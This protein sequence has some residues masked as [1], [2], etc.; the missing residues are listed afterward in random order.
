MAWLIKPVGQDT[1]LLSNNIDIQEDDEVFVIPER[2][3][4]IPYPRKVNIHSQIDDQGF[5]KDLVASDLKTNKDRFGSIWTEEIELNEEY[6]RNKE[7]I[8]YRVAYGKN[9]IYSVSQDYFK[10]IG[11]GRYIYALANREH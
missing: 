10:F 9:G 7:S 1:I 2:T 3:G 5:G 4:S 8:K 11:N 6:T